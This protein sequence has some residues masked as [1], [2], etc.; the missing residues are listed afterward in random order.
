[1]NLCVCGGGRSNDLETKK[2]FSPDP[3]KSRRTKSWTLFITFITALIYR[4]SP[5]YVYFLVYTYYVRVMVVV[6]GGCGSQRLLCLNLVRIS[7]WC[8]HF[9]S[10]I[11]SISQ[12]WLVLIAAS[13]KV[14][15]YI[16]RTILVNTMETEKHN[17]CGNFLS[18]NTT[19]R[20]LGFNISSQ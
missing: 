18:N 7:D 14:G 2:Y 3:Q 1:M 4:S 15:G 13:K 20:F 16:T 19:S 11:F 9:Y 10:N 8:C 5:K 12:R 17:R 6:V